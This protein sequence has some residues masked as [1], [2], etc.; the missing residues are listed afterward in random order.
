MTR[1]AILWFVLLLATLPAC[2]T[3]TKRPRPM[4][5][6]QYTFER[7]ELVDA[8][9]EIAVTDA[10]SLAAI[11]D[12]LERSKEVADDTETIEFAEKKKLRLIGSTAETSRVY[13]VDLKNGYATILSKQVLPIYRISDLGRLNEILQA[14]GKPPQTAR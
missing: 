7:V 10:D 12:I 13:I 11:K 5:S 2:A 9:L 14:A 1:L 8:E 6:P 4:I 3:T